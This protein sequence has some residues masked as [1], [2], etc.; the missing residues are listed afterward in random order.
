MASNPPT[1]PSRHA[2]RYLRQVALGGSTIIG[3]VGGI[4]GV[5]T[6][7]YDTH[8]RIRMAERLIETKKTIRSVS[9]A[10]GAAHVARMFEAAERGEE[11][12]LEATRRQT[13]HR[14]RNYTALAADRS[15]RTPTKDWPQVQNLRFSD[16]EVLTDTSKHR[17]LPDGEPEPDPTKGLTT[18]P[19][20]VSI[21]G[22]SSCASRSRPAAALSTQS[23][24]PQRPASKRSES[25]ESVKNSNLGQ[26]Q[27]YRRVPTDT[28]SSKSMKELATLRDIEF[29]ASSGQCVIDRNSAAAQK[30]V[31]ATQMQHKVHDHTVFGRP[32]KPRS[33][34]PKSLTECV[35]L[36]LRSEED[37]SHGTRTKRDLEGHLSSTF[38]GDKSKQ[39]GS[40]KFSKGRGFHTV[41]QLSSSRSSDAISNAGSKHVQPILSKVTPAMPAPRQSDASDDHEEKIG[42]GPRVDSLASPGPANGDLTEK[43]LIQAEIPW[44]PTQLTSAN[45]LG[46]STVPLSSDLTVDFLTASDKDDTE[47][48]TEP[49]VP[50]ASIQSSSWQPFCT[51]LPLDPEFEKA[52]HTA[53]KMGFATWKRYIK[54][55]AKVKGPKEGER[56]WVEAMTFYAAP[57]DHTD[58]VMVNRLHREFYTSFPTLIQHHPVRHLTRQALSP[59]VPSDRLARLLFPFQKILIR[60][61]QNYKA[62][63]E[64]GST[65]AE[66]RDLFANVRRY[67]EEFW[68]EEMDAGKLVAELR[69]VIRV[70]RFRNIQLQED[71]FVSPIRSLSSVGQMAKAQALFDEMVYYHQ[72]QPSFYTRTP[73]IHGFARVGDW[74]RVQKD[75][76]TLHY[77]DESRRR[78]FGYSTMF[79]HVFREYAAKKPIGQTHDFLVYALGY[80]GLV[81]TSAISTTAIQAYLTNQRYDLLREW[82]ETVRVMFPQVE[83]QTSSFAWHVGSTW[84]QVNATCQQVEE[85]CR[86]ITYKKDPSKVGQS[87]RAVVREALA[88]D[89]AAK[90]HA[91]EAARIVGDNVNGSELDGSLGLEAYLE[92]ARDVASNKVSKT[93][94]QV[95]ESREAQ[96]LLSQVQSATRLNS[97][98]S[99]GTDG[100]HPEPVNRTWSPSVN[101]FQ[102]LV[103]PPPLAQVYSRFPTA[104]KRELL[105]SLSTTTQIVNQYYMTQD[106]DGVPVDHEIARYVCRKLKA[107]GR[108]SDA[109]RLL[110]SIYHGPH[111]QGQDGTMF[112]LPTMELWLRLACEMKSVKHCRAVLWAVLKAAELKLTDRFLVLVD[113]SG[114]KT[115]NNRF[116]AVYQNDPRGS[117]EIDWLRLRLK[118]KLSHQRGGKTRKYDLGSWVT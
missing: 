5:A 13:K 57:G 26:S 19:K 99:S 109:L 95:V 116:N 108:Q 42:F 83:T 59:G 73:L 15:Q 86:A 78:P 53:K 3:T 103:V 9:N 52:V 98:F 118:A 30:I 70:A 71:L 104:L 31:A 84:E 44:L 23:L 51:G 76:E 101:P 10:N 81:P 102:E 14:A 48:E 88:R 91:A 43:P 21:S 66:G 96:E 65:R 34:P 12:G 20:Q 11:F 29:Q 92:R 39:T 37:V 17:Q 32:S 38:H 69:K 47:T 1:A 72:I 67:L 94:L 4:C 74:I 62:I 35:D 55:T 93:Q 97:L 112:D 27:I 105:P 56:L 90:L 50:Y 36:W 28:D 33:I 113:M 7:N 41:R 114:W 82:I 110:E 63:G 22:D 80:W 24:S 46:P 117:T 89:L 45:P 40:P 16:D 75:I 60:K 87:F 79:N 61:Q 54:N 100:S 85:A 115:Q 2:L 68:D 8:R 58:W 6:L 107:Q 111:V 77:E 64:S 25:N 106:A 18:L 49:N